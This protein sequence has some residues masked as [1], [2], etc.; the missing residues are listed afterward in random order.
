MIFYMISN[1]NNRKK[2][3]KNIIIFTAL[4]A[5]LLTGLFGAYK[6]KQ[7]YDSEHQYD[8]RILVFME[9]QSPKEESIAMFNELMRTDTLDEVTYSSEENEL[10]NAF[11]H[12]SE[13]EKSNWESEAN[14]LYSKFVCL[15]KSE[16]DYDDV[17][18]ELKK[19]E[20]STDSCF[21]VTKGDY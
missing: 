17:Y 19:L 2:Y 18:M 4:S 14:P 15:P 13:Q 16:L 5:I 7:F 11:S 12:L 20:T 9:M 6:Y 21:L 1:G 8:G 3:K 10:R